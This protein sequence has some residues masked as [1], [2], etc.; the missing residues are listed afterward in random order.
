MYKELF[1]RQLQCQDTCRLAAVQQSSINYTLGG[2]VVHTIPHLLVSA[3][4]LHAQTLCDYMKHQAGTLEAP[5][6]NHKCTRPIKQ[7][8]RPNHGAQLDTSSESVRE[9]DALSTS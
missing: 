4:D 1:H 5:C 8:G 2:L 7:I 3:Q 9:R 6:K